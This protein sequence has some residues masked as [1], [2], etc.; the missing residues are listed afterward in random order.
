[1]VHFL[2]FLH[3]TLVRG[4]LVPCLFSCSTIE[5]SREFNRPEAPRRNLQ[6][7]FGNLQA[8]LENLQALFE[9]LQAPCRNLQGL[10]AKI[11]RG[12]IFVGWLFSYIVVISTF[13]ATP[14]TPTTPSWESRGA[15]VSR[16]LTFAYYR[17]REE[18]FRCRKCRKCTI[19]LFSY[20][21]AKGGVFRCVRCTRCG[22]CTP[23]LL[24]ARARKQR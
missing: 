12:R 15:W 23:T 6:A 13:W 10:L 20:A 14:V 21:R 9:N 16:H 5:F 18:A 2:H 22:R 24:L 1:M 19:F 4:R 3:L 17:A 8:S 7:T 11:C